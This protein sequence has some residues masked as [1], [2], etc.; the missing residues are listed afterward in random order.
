MS[1]FLE[2]DIHHVTRDMSVDIA[3]SVCAV[4]FSQQL[5]GMMHVLWEDSKFSWLNLKSI[6][7]LLEDHFST[8]HL[9]NSS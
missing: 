9:H 6:D 5:S 8:Q 4:F 7:C 3:F 2:V 1:A